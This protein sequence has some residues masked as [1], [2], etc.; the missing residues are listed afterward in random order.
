MYQEMQ[1][2]KQDKKAKPS[3]ARRWGARQSDAAKEKKRESGAADAFGIRYRSAGNRLAP[4]VQ[5]IIAQEGETPGKG[6]D[7]IMRMF[8]NKYSGSTY[9]SLFLTLDASETQISVVDVGSRPSRY[10]P[11]EK[12]LYLNFFMLRQLWEDL[13]DEKSN[14]AIISGLLSNIC[15]EL[16]HAYD[17]IGDKEKRPRESLSEDGKMSDTTF[18]STE[19]R[20][21]AR[22]AI[23][24]LEIN[25]RYALAV[26][27]ANPELINGWIQ[28][29]PDMLDYLSGNRKNGIIKRLIHYIN[30]RLN[31]PNQ[32]EEIQEWMNV[33]SARKEKYKEQIRR[34]QASVVRKMEY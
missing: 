23:S 15:H 19:L 24:I 13:E 10:D 4:V 8:A 18:I 14:A 11:L 34:L 6:V 7:E 21:W 22:E 5:R 2:K 16:S 31:Y 33:D 1:L 32:I 30:I 17:F 28:V 12:K 26:E 3:D 27:K 29:I 25:K 20:A 9:S